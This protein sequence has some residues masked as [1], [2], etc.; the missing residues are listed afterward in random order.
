[1]L[2]SPQAF[3]KANC[4]HCKA[5]VKIGEWSRGGLTRGDTEASDHDMGCKEKYV[6]CGIVDASP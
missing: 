3:Y 6:P 1:M 4:T 5:T 2:L